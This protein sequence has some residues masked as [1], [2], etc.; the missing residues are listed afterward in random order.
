MVK[1]DRNEIDIHPDRSRVVRLIWIIQE[2][3]SNPHQGIDQFISRAG[4][5]RSQFYKDRASLADFGFTFDYK[6]GYG[7]HVTE[8][9]LSSA[10]DL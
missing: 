8:D 2:V 3:R 6:K 1:L 10:Q 4:I 7:F 9:R 5:S